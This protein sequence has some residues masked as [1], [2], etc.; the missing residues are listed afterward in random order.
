MDCW[1]VAGWLP[2][3]AGWT[4][5]WLAG[6]NWLAGWTDWRVVRHLSQL[7]PTVVPILVGT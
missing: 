3:L 1:L 4:A 2:G 6:L 5:G 7:G